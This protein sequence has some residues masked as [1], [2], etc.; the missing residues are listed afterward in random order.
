MYLSF[1]GDSGDKIQGN[2]NDGSNNQDTTC[3]TSITD[4]NW[5][6]AVLVADRSASTPK[7]KVYLDKSL[8]INE[9]ITAVGIIDAEGGLYLG[10]D[11]NI[12]DILSGAIDE[13]K[14][15]NRALS[16]EEVTKNYNHG[17]S[18]HS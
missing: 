2:I 12:A 3:A 9:T 4:N 5:H 6:H 14:Y 11:D 10:C 8:D 16:L 7:L 17:K 1:R 18:K 15:Y 13:V